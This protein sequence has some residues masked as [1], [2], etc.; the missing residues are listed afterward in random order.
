MPETIAPPRWVIAAFVV[1]TLL[2]S[3]WL[4]FR[5]NSSAEARECRARY[6]S[7]RSA[8]DTAIVDLSLPTHD[9]TD[10][11]THSCGFIRRGARW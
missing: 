5:V 9:S 3:G 8:A 10:V 4:M 11:E 1:A 7:A 6:Q 2:V